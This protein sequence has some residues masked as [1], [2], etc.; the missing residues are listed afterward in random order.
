MVPFGAGGLLLVAAAI[1]S[2]SIK[3]KRYS[4]RYRLSTAS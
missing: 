3:E 1:V 4:T 2:L